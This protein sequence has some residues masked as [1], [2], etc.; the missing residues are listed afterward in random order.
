VKTIAMSGLDPCSRRYRRLP[1]MAVA[2]I[3][4]DAQVPPRVRLD[5][6]LFIAEAG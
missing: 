3:A 4:P 6:G 5:T 1:N 2:R